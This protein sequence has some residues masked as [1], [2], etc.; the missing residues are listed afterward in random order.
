LIEKN[1]YNLQFLFRTVARMSPSSVKPCIALILSSDD[2][3]S[4][5][6]NK[7]VYIREKIK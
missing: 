7:M 1:N 2:F 4:F 6:T 5:F 3:I